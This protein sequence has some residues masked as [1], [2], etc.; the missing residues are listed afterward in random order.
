V[1][2]TRVPFLTEG[3]PGVEPGDLEW[4]HRVTGAKKASLELF[5]PWTAGAGLAHCFTLVPTDFETQGP[6]RLVLEAKART[7]GLD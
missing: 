6:H 1:F 3:G 2:L 5:S 4:S 7:S